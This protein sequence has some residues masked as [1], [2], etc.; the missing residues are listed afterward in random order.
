MRYLGL[1][2]DLLKSGK[3]I[4]TINGQNILGSGDLQVGGSSVIYKLTTPTPFIDNISLETNIINYEFPA[5]FFQNGDYI[6]ITRFFVRKENTNG[7]TFVLLYFT[8]DPLETKRIFGPGFIK[9]FA[10]SGGFLNMLCQRGINV[11]EDGFVGVNFE[12]FDPDDRG[13]Y[14]SPLEVRVLDKSLPIY[15]NVAVYMGSVLD[16]IKIESLVINRH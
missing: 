14:S 16:K 2:Q 3:N 8:N 6:D 9:G 7:L 12:N 11:T 15:L 1:K 10:L 5:N 4:K 13:V